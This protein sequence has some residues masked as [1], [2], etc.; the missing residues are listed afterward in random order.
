MFQAE[1]IVSGYISSRPNP[2]LPSGIMF[3]FKKK[4]ESW[5]NG[6][7]IQ[8]REIQ[9]IYPYIYM[10]CIY[11]YIIIYIYAYIYIYIH[12][13]AKLNCLQDFA[14]FLPGQVCFKHHNN[15]LLRRLGNCCSCWMVWKRHRN[16]LVALVT[17]LRRREWD[18][19]QGRR[20]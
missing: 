19:Q 18:Q 11:I 2:L 20:E 6:P 14:R 7:T 15:L 12:M 5:P 1:C 10:I 4:G 3:F 16:L 9:C 8:L 13:P 17:C